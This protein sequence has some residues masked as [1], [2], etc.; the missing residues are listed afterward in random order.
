MLAG[1]GGEQRAIERR[2]VA[3]VLAQQVAAVDFRQ[4]RAGVERIDDQIFHL[5]GVAARAPGSGRGS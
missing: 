2:F 4:Q 1:R 5:A 3:D